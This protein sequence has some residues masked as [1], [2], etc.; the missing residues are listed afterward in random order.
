MFSVGDKV[1]LGR[2][3]VLEWTV[4]KVEASGTLHVEALSAAGRRFRYAVGSDV[5]AVKG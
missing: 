2:H 5:H 4:V 1:T 3:G